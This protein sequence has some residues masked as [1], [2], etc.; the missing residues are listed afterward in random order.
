MQE[1]GIADTLFGLPTAFIVVAVI[2]FVVVV[3][4]M[5]IYTVMMNRMEAESEADEAAPPPNYFA[6]AAPAAGGWAPP[7][8]PLHGW[9]V[10]CAAFMDNGATWLNMPKDDAE[11]MLDSGWGV[12]D[13]ESLQ[14]VLGDL[15]QAPLT[16]WNAVRLFRVALAGVRA[17]YIGSDQAFA[18]IRPVAQRLQA[19]YPSFDAIWNDYIVNLRGF[20]HL[21]TDGSGDDAEIAKYFR[22][23]GEIKNAHFNGVDYRAVL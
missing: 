21:P 11:E 8:E 15:A 14:G 5:T 6:N 4:G 13:A 16:G 3:A 9:V 12:D 2:A 20:K 22:K 17:G 1:S 10:M 7:Q 23:G 19:A 18:G